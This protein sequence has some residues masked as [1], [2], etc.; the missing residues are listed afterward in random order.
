MP[1]RRAL[2]EIVSLNCP[3]DS[4]RHFSETQNCDAPVCS[5]IIFP[6]GPW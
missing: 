6:S 4:D 5:T 1:I 3:V 2:R